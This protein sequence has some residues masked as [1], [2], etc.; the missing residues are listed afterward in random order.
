M[1][2]GEGQDFHCQ[3]DIYIGQKRYAANINQLRSIV[4]DLQDQAESLGKE[5]KRIIVKHVHP[6][7]EIIGKT[8]IVLH[9]L[10]NADIDLKERLEL[11]VGKPVEVQALTPSLIKYSR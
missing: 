1:I 2:I 3:S 6:S 9:P 7:L 8:G 4:L 5:L 10:T 11:I